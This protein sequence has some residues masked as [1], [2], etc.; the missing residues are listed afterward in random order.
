MNRNQKEAIAARLEKLTKLNKGRL[1]PAN[2]MHD[3]RNLKSPQHDQFE[4]DDGKASEQYRL[5]QAR[6]LIRTV[7]LEIRTERRIISTVRYVRDPSANQFEQGYVDVTSL[8]NNKTLAYEALEDELKRAKVSMDRALD[9]AETL[10]MRD[11]V[12]QIIEHI[13]LMQRGIEK[14]AA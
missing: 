3:A 14:Q 9:F 2:V 4:W 11:M 1:T 10:N 7:R 5:D 13:E 6:T 8:R 12:D